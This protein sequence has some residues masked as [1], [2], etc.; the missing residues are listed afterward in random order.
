MYVDVLSVRN[1]RLPP[2]VVIAV[3]VVVVVVVVQKLH[4]AT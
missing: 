3:V 1:D 4:N 2:R